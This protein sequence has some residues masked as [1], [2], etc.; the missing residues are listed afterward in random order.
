MKVEKR[1]DKRFDVELEQ[2]DR[3]LDCPFCGHPHPSLEHTWTASYWLECVGC[4]AEVHDNGRIGGAESQS[5]H[6]ASARRVVK[7]W[8]TRIV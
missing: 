1:G 8:N 7:R 4:G 6:L 5:A 3:L 2:G